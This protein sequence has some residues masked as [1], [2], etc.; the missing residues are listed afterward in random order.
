MPAPILREAFIER[1]TALIPAS[2]RLG[3]DTALLL[4]DLHNLTQINHRHSFNLGDAMLST[5]FGALRSA[6]QDERNVFRIGTHTFAVLLPGMTVSHFVA[7]AASQVRDAVSRALEEYHEFTPPRLVVGASMTQG[8]L[9]PPMSLLAQ[10]E[11]NLS[12]ARAG[13]GL[14]IESMLLASADDLL[15]DQL[16]RPF[17]D[18]L[19]RNEF[20]VY[21]QPQVA[22]TDGQV[23]GAEALIRWQ[24]DDR[25]FIN[26]ERI[27]E[28]AAQAGKTFE[29]ARSITNKVVRQVSQWRA[30]HDSFTVSINVSADLLAN[31][32]LP[33]VLTNAIGIWG[34]SANSVT[35]E[36]TEE[37]IVANL[38]SN[39][40][41]L[42][43]LRDLGFGLSIDDFGTGYSSLAYLRR[44]PATELKIDRSFLVD[45]LSSKQ[46]QRLLAL[47]IDMAH[48]FGMEAVVEGVE[49]RQTQAL[50]MSLECDVIQGWLVGQ[51]MPPEDFARWLDDW[52]G[53][54]SLPE[55]G[56]NPIAWR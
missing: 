13:G 55:T 33:V 48:L 51:A 38:E 14:D 1:M 12:R 39:K 46:D 5:V 47:M 11:I 4:V 41:T 2:R 29:F 17:E 36:I 19:H 27:V 32:D 23:V 49:D 30:R 24:L 26:P 22:C 56:L 37:T 31:A 3:H 43:E 42:F 25:G 44:I 35:L 54:P 28:L 15:G 8:A 18:A 45:S 50:L 40:R 52:Q 10:A 20:D 16:E 9:M 53:W 6:V 34:V 21:F 7:I